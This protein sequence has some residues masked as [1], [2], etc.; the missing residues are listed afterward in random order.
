MQQLRYPHLPLSLPILAART[1]V[2]PL[3]PLIPPNPVLALP[4]AIRARIVRLARLGLLLL[5]HLDQPV[6]LA[7]L[8]LAL[9]APLGDPFAAR[10]IVHQLAVALL[11]LDALLG[12]KALPFGRLF[13]GGDGLFARQGHAGGR[14][15][16]VHAFR[17]GFDLACGE[18]LVDEG[19]GGVAR[20]CGEGGFVRGRGDGVGV[21]GEKVAEVEGEGCGLVYGD[22]PGR[23]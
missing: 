5:I 21:V 15:D 18:E 14:E 20:G 16:E 2:I 13:G 23:C 22:G 8:V 19:L 7:V 17:V 1:I 11:V 12:G 6:V 9:V 10:L 4:P 3:L